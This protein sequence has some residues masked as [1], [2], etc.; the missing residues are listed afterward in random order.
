MLWKKLNL[1]IKLLLYLKF[2][3]LLHLNTIIKYLLN[4]KVK[5]FKF[6]VKQKKNKTNEKNESINGH[7]RS[8]KVC[9]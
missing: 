2:I 8:E 9:G 6:K 7:C 4:K 5:Q 1:D 3:T